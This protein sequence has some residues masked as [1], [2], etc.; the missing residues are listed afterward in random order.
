MSETTELHPLI[1]SR[2]SPRSYSDRPV[3]PAALRSLF[4]A[5]RWAASCFN[6][7]PWRWVVAEKANPS[8]YQRILDTLV[9]FNQ[10][11]AGNAPVLAISAAKGTF[12]Q[13]GKPNRFGMFDTGQALA[14]LMLQ[15]TAL[16]LHVHAMGGF[17]AEKARAEFGIP[18]DYEVGAA[19]AIGH[20]ADGHEP[21][22]RQRNP[23]STQVF[24]SAWGT[25]LFD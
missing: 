10:G 2:W 15:A 17:D 18:E 7:Q 9:P 12:T 1:S 13:N 23:L 11:W 6:E 25:P 19:I 21:G 14:T 4:E 24:R 20:L 16:G 8:E 3:E 22:E 5:A